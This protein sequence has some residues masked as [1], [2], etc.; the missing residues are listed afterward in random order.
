MSEAVAT[1]RFDT[2]RFDVERFAAPLRQLE[3]L[4]GSRA[5]L[6]ACQDRPPFPKSF[7]DSDL[8]VLYDC[9]QALG[10][11]KHL[12]LV[13][14]S[15]GGKV[16]VTRRLYTLL[17][18]YAQH[19]TIFVPY[20]ARSSAT[21]LCLGANELVMTPLSELGPLDPHISAA[22]GQG[23][24]VVSAED[25]R[26]YRAVAEDWFGITAEAHRMELFKGLSERIFPTTLSNFYRADK[27]MRQFACEFLAAQLPGAT[28][29]QR[30]AVADQLISGYFEHDY[31]IML[32]EA[33]ALGLAARA[34]STEEE[35]LLSA[36]RR[37]YGAAFKLEV[38]EVGVPGTTREEHTNGLLVGTTF[39]ARHLVSVE[40]APPPPAH[41]S[42][43][44]VTQS[45][46]S[47]WHVF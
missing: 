12:D 13:L 18:Q 30:E 20:K 6:F 1:E 43:M 32:E 15:A 25:I 38:G 21:L 10:P 7:D 17:R 44:T 4:R 33:A 37:A 19:L 8:V 29:A 14:H 39:T 46:K 34:S 2:E 42:G 23:P 3:T 5:L 27:Q 41:S 35:A 45:I 26:A 47:R 24:A 28:S 40:Q 11:V 9:L 22:S 16:T 36:L 31:P